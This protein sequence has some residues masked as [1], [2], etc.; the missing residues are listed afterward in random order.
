MCSTVNGLRS[1]SQLKLAT[2]KLLWYNVHCVLTSNVLI[3]HVLQKIVE[4]F[5]RDYSKPATEDVAQRSFLLS[6]SRI[7]LVYH[8]SPEHITQNTREFVIPQLSADQGFNLTWSPDMTSAYHADLHESEPKDREL[9][10]LLEELVKIQ[11]Q[12]QAIVRT[13][14]QEVLYIYPAIH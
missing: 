13:S 5:E 6:E 2:R 10:T 7:E 11:E 9:F 14:E 12:S 1:L 8:L 3:I 4:E